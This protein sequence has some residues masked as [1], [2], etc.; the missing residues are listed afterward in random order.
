MSQRPTDF[1]DKLVALCKTCNS[2]GNNTRN[3]SICKDYNHQ[4]DHKLHVASLNVIKAVLIFHFHFLF[5]SLFWSTSMFLYRLPAGH[6]FLK[7]IQSHFSHFSSSSFRLGLVSAAQEVE[8][9]LWFDPCLLQCACQISNVVL[10]RIIMHYNNIL[11][12]KSK[13]GT[14]KC[15]CWVLPTL[16]STWLRYH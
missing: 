7:Y 9:G 14:L 2:D 12:Q 1:W 16:S 10:S 15:F 4:I 3:L 13:N 8:Q 6:Q 5:W 11:L